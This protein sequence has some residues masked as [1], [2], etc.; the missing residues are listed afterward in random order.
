MSIKQAK[1]IVNESLSKENEGDLTGKI[2]I[3]TKK[4]ILIKNKQ[5]QTKY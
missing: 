5:K 4:K 1:L 2:E 3:K